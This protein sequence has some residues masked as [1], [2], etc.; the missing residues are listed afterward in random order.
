MENVFRGNLVDL[1]NHRIFPAEVTVREGCI[2]SI[3]EVDEVFSTYLAPG[4]VD[5]HVHVESSLLIPTEFARLAVRHGTVATVSDPHEI[6]NVLGLEGVEFMLRNAAKTP[7]KIFFGAPSCVPATPFETAGASLGVVEVEQLLQKDQIL[8]LS[9]MMNFPGVVNGDVEVHEKLRLARLYGKPVD[10]H[11]PGLRGEGLRRYVE[12]GIRN[13]HECFTLE[14][15]MEKREQGM[16]IVIRE[17]SAA[18]NFDELL[19]LLREFPKDCLFC[20]DD[21]HLDNLE[22]GHINRLVARSV[23]GGVDALVALRVAS[24]QAVEHYGL[25]VGF[26]REGD[27]ADFV[28]LT[29]L[30]SFDVRRTILEGEVVAEN[31]QTFLPSVKE[32]PVN[33]FAAAEVGAA[34][35]TIKFTKDP[36]AQVRVIEALEN[37]LV[38]QEQVVQPKVREKE[39]VT[40]PTRDILKLVVHNRYRPAKPA[41]ALAK[42]FGLHRGAIASSVGHDSHN[43]LA[44]GVDDQ[45]LARALEVLRQHGGGLVA[46][47]AGGEEAFFP[48]PVAGLMTNQDAFSS[49]RD[50]QRVEE[51]AHRL[52]SPLRAPFMTLSFMALL[53]IPDLKLSDQGLFDGRSFSFV[54][55]I[56]C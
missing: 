38:T 25:P 16:K 6:A 51:L 50:Y 9:E 11:A 10:G 23:A 42:G 40:D 21:M 52:G 29:D 32:A 8:Y 18:K 47:D 28:E 45:S 35:L 2:A 1:V 12:A 55:I 31:G 15:A 22:L 5:A 44:V 34:D 30:V 7:L 19:P 3:R 41:V 39:I 43:L 17:G 27:P 53:V 33:K 49:V 54:P 24:V 4:F 56:S 36:P 48:L 46:C 13:D 37:Q 26:L 20:T 14:E